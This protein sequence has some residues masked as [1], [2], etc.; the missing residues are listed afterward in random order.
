MEEEYGGIEGSFVGRQ[1]VYKNAKVGEEE[2][3]VDDATG[4]VGT[5]NLHG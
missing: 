2:E 5:V 3:E 1:T 4:D